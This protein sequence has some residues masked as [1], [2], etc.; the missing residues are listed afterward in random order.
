M[1]ISGSIY[2]RLEICEFTSS[3]QVLNLNKE[4]AN[5]R[6]LNRIC[7]SFESYWAVCTNFK[8]P[9]SRAR[10][11]QIGPKPDGLKAGT[12]VFPSVPKTRP[13]DVNISR[14]GNIEITSPIEQVHRKTMFCISFDYW[15]E[16][17]WIILVQSE[18]MVVNLISWNN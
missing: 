5:L 12:L 16:F 15:F 14:Y 7:W 6:I 2:G 9:I 13:E 4:L 8:S 17:D 3:K 1:K 18:K 10:D 11:V